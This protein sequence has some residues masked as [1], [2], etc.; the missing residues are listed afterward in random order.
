MMT[1]SEEKCWKQIQ[2]LLPKTRSCKDDALV[3][4]ILAWMEN[5]MVTDL[6][7]NQPKK[8]VK[9]TKSAY[10]VEKSLGTASLMSKQ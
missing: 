10:S 5:N 3:N 2:L 8:N 4:E 6:P 9:M 1:N 7:L